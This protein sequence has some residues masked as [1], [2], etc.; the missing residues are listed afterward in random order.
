MKKFKGLFFSFE[1][2]D[3][4]GKS[5]VIKKIYESLKKDYSVEITRE[6]GGNVSSSEK[7][8][9][10]LLNNLLEPETEALLFAA[11]RTEHTKKFIIPSLEQGKIVLSDRYIDSSLVYQGVGRDIGIKEIEKINDFGI[12]GFRPDYVFY[13]D[14]DLNTSLK[15]TK[16]NNRSNNIMDDEAYKMK[17]KIHL[18]FSFINK[19]YKKNHIIIDASK[20]LNDVVEEVNRRIRI[21][22]EKHYENKYK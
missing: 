10:I 5:T 7:I 18:G 17:D 12:K 19:K 20:P 2:I 4:S 3:G 13:F 9:D 16:N 15:R 8:R 11:S 21:I 1:G 22:I 14:I 6:P